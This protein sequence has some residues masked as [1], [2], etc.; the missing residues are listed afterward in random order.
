MI[1]HILL[2]AKKAGSRLYTHFELDHEALFAACGKLKGD[3]IMTYDNAEEVKKLARKHQFMAKPI[4]MKNTHHAAMTEL[5]IGRDLS[6][7]R[8]S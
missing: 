5:V 2:V 6:W 8:G 4:P 7:M 1:P 3:F